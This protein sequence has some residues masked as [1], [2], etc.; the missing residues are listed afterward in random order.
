MVS[1]NRLL[2]VVC[3]VLYCLISNCARLGRDPI[4]TNLLDV[5]LLHS[6]LCCKQDIG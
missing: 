6:F 5:E 3:N 4:Q 2:D 1:A